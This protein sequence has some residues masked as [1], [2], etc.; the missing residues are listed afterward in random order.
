MEDKEKEKQIIQSMDDAINRLENGKT[1]FI[2]LTPDTQGVGRSSVIT[3]Y[4]H[5]KGLKDLGYEAII[6]HEKNEYANTTLWLGNEFT[7]IDHIS[8]ESQQLKVSPSDILVLPEIFGNVIEKTQNMPV[9]RVVLVQSAEHLLDNYS[10]AKTWAHNGIIQC[11]TT[12]DKLAEFVKEVSPITNVNVVIPY[13]PEYFKPSDK[14]KKPVI[15]LHT[16]DPKKT[17]KFVKEFL[18]KYP[19]LSWIPVR[20][21]YGMSQPDFA[22]QLKECAVSVWLDREAGFGR[23]AIESMLCNVPVIGVVPDMPQ[24]WINENSGVWLDTEN[25]VST[26]MA[27]YM[28]NFIEDNLPEELK[29]VRKWVENIYVEETNFKNTLKE[30]Y[31]NIINYRIDKLK[32]IKEERLKIFENVEDVKNKLENIAN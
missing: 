15:A 3:M 26:L 9:E 14:P 29:D 32:K 7:D 4:Q 30:S 6:L 31:Q 16:K 28:K 5:A 1:R 24:D 17:A 18:V 27:S 21:M 22:R 20:H 11:I 19:N 10:P 8:I 2:F 13:I 23:Y 12:S 25:M